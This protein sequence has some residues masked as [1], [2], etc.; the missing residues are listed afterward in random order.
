MAEEPVEFLP[1][2]D[3]LLVEVAR[4]PVVQNVTDVPDDG[5]WT[6]QP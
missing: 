5:A 6:G 4:V 3:Q 2:G 1:V